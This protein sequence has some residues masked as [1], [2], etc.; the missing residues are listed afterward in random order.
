[1]E[2]Y[3]DLLNTLRKSYGKDFDNT[4]QAEEVISYLKERRV[5][6]YSLDALH[7]FI[8]ENEIYLP[9]RKAVWK[10]II[11]KAYGFSDRK[12]DEQRKKLLPLHQLERVKDWTAEEILENCRRIRN[13]QLKLWESG[14]AT[15]NLESRYL[16]FLSV[17][18]RLNDVEEDFRETAKKRI[19]ENGQK[20]LYSITKVDLSDLQKELKPVDMEKI[21]EKNPVRKVTEIPF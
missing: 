16:S 2:T 21:Y 19:L 12:I 8:T 1:M 5:P 6:L 4:Y 9:K 18:D 7:K 11:D 14:L 15:I 3:G 17:W 10:Q 13:R 20:E